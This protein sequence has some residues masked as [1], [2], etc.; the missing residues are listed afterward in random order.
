MN[1]CR[2]AA[3]QQRKFW[4]DFTPGAEIWCQESQKKYRIAGD[5]WKAATNNIPHINEERVTF[6]AGANVG[7][8]ALS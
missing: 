8:I 7:I 1:S 4:V 2:M 3:G 6:A 5:F